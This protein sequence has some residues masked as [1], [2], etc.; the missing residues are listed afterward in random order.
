MKLGFDGCF[1]QDCQGQKGG[2]ILL[3]KDPM[4]VEIKSCTPGHIDV[5][6]EHD[7]GRWRFIGFYGCPI[8]E[9]NFFLG[10]FLRN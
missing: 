1:I 6:V 5:V 8:V 4:R 10:N 2:L 3:W 9:N 7:G